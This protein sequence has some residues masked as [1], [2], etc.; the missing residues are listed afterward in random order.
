MKLAGIVEVEEG[1]RREKEEEG[2]GGVRKREK[3]RERCYSRSLHVTR[4][5]LT[6]YDGISIF[7]IGWN[8]YT[9]LH[10]SSHVGYRFFVNVRILTPCYAHAW[11][12][13]ANS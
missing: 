11:A 5:L 8:L 12:A 1:G 10:S 4:T 7:K 3:R 9:N 6:E 13:G 2:R